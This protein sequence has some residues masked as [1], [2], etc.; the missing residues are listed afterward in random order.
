MTVKA[1]TLPKL[2]A[3]GTAAAMI[4]VASSQV[5]YREG[6]NND[7]TYGRAYGMNNVAWCAI[8]IS[9]SASKA[10]CESCIP[11]HAYTPSG[12]QWFKAR[13]QWGSKPKVGAIVYF[14][15]AGMGRISHVGVVTAVH[16]D[17]SFDT[18][19]GNTNDNGS[20]IGNGV[21][22]LRRRNVGTRG[23]FG[24][25]KY[26]KAVSEAPSPPADVTVKLS[27]A[28]VPNHANSQVKLL[29]TLLIAAGYG[30]GIET[31]VG[32]MY[33]AGAQKAVAHFHD[34]HPELKSP[35]L[36]Y[37]PA[38]GPEGFTLLQRLAAKKAA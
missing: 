30:H 35:G 25:P 14:D 38:I 2:T 1:K 24:Y 29:K 20:R 37:D 13:D 4:A 36:K 33:G 15:T 21:Y 11:K 31:P 28:V 16:D 17:G 32:P 6:A 9:W 23:G 27:P 3:L 5:G 22:R 34:D 8:F 12:A 19:E 26:A 18:V 10:G 7:T